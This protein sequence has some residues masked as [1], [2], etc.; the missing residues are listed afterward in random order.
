MNNFDKY[1]DKGLTGLSNLGNTCFLNSTIQCLSHTYELNDVLEKVDFGE[2]NMEN[3]TLLCNEWNSLRKLMWKDNCMISPGRFIKCVHHIAKLKKRDIFTGFAQNDLPEFFL[4]FMEELH[5]ALNKK[6]EIKEKEEGSKLEKKCFKVIKDL[7]N[8]EYSEIINLFYGIHV[9]QIMDLE[10]E[11]I[12]IQNP[13]PF[14]MIDLPIPD[15]RRISIKDCFDLYTKKEIMDEENMWYNE[16]TKEKEQVKK[17]ILFHSL[18]QIMVVDFKRFHNNTK[19]NN[20]LI[21]FPINNLNLS[22]YIIENKSETYIYDCYGICNHSGSSLGGHYTAFIRN[23][24]DEWYH[25]NDTRVTK[26]NSTKDL[27]SQKAYC[28]FFRK[29]IND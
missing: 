2:N 19:K 17:Q 9:S 26:M 28:L 8:K 5:N 22:E 11:K 12:Y 3:K 7:Y 4:F 10:K 15:K 18:P 14:F 6:I 13:E 21:D 16:E 23:A 29:K 1:E 20:S 27:V 25:F 24:N